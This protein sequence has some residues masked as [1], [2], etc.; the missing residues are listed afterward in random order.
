MLKCHAV[1]WSLRASHLSKA[2]VA[3]AQIPELDVSFKNFDCTGS[4][5]TQNC[6][7]SN[8]INSSSVFGIFSSST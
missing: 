4:R 2:L 8:S 5:K 3:K 6:S 7:L 1:T